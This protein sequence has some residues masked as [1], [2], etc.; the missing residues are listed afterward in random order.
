MGILWTLPAG[1]GIECLRR[2]VYWRPDRGSRESR[3]RLCGCRNDGAVIG[4]GS[5][6]RSVRSPSVVAKTEFR[7]TESHRSG[8]KLVWWHRDCA[9]SRTRRILCGDRFCGGAQSWARAPELQSLM[10]RAVRNAKAPIF[11]FQAAND[12][13]LSPS[14][15]LSAEMNEVSKTYKLKIYPP[16]RRLPSGRPQLWLLWSRRLGRRRFR[17]SEPAL[18]QVVAFNPPRA[19]H[20]RNGDH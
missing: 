8:G 13:D 18:H 9:G 16:L 3:R 6:G 20:L 14:K 7:S 2:S 12:F 15:T 17:I 10:T 1:T 19:T 11:F 5:F 4:D